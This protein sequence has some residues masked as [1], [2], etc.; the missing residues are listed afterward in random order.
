VIHN[1]KSKEEGIV[2]EQVV[3][4]EVKIAIEKPNRLG[5]IINV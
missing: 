2:N 1:E 3:Y 4:C 5:E